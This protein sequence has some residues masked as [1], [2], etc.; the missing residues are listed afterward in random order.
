MT[1]ERVGFNPTMISI[2]AVFVVNV[3]L[4]IV[5]VVYWNTVHFIPRLFFVGFVGSIFDTLGKVTSLTALNY[6][7]GGPSTAL[8][9]LNGPYLVVLVALTS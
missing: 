1:S 3:I 2:S 8:C 4:L 7:P 5:A 9:S 6:G